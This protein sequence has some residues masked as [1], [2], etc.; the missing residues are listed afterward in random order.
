MEDFKPDFKETDYD[1]HTQNILEWQ[2]VI[3]LKEKLKY[4]DNDITQWDPSTGLRRSTLYGDYKLPGFD[5]HRSYTSDVAPSVKDMAEK[6]LPEEDWIF[7]EFLPLQLQALVD[8]QKAAARDAG[9][10]DQYGEDPVWTEFY[11]KGR[12]PPA[13]RGGPYNN[14]TQYS[15]SGG[16]TSWSAMFMGFDH[17]IPT[18]TS[19]DQLLEQ[20]DGIGQYNENNTTKDYL[21]QKAFTRYWVNQLVDRGRGVDVYENMMGIS[22]DGITDSSRLLMGQDNEGYGTFAVPW[23]NKDDQKSMTLGRDDEFLTHGLF[24]PYAQKPYDAWMSTRDETVTTEETDLSPEDVAKWEARF[25]AADEEAA[26]ADEQPDTDED[27]QPVTDKEGNI[28]FEPDET[29]KKYVPGIGFVG[30]EQPDTDVETVIEEPVDWSGVT[31]TLPQPDVGWAPADWGGFTETQDNWTGSGPDVDWTLPTRE[32]DEVA[33]EVEHIDQPR[34]PHL[35]SLTPFQEYVAE[36][37][38][39]DAGT[40]PEGGYDWLAHD[41]EGHPALYGDHTLEQQLGL[42]SSVKAIQ[43]QQG[44]IHEFFDPTQVQPA[45]SSILSAGHR[46]G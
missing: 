22:H 30:G 7:D 35:T 27:E 31:D 42:D 21:V 41:V 5:I 18:A 19:Y 4:G 34:G 6:N 26:K 43:S 29:T 10:I 9:Y 23:A 14:P 12:M 37:H 44:V 13:H 38:P 11:S 3:N 46:A 17:D 45:F 2:K 33:E 8:S 28:V 25:E 32:P 36:E 15:S 1:E 20:I 24:T 40:V 16:Q 39:D